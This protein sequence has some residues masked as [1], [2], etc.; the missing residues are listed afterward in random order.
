MKPQDEFAVIVAGVVT[1][2]TFQL[3]NSAGVVVAELGT[4]SIAGVGAA[5]LTMNHTDALTT[6]SALAWTT[7][8]P[9][10]PGIESVAL[11]GPTR[12]AAGVGGARTGGS[13]A[14][15]LGA[16]DQSLELSP[17]SAYG[18]LVGETAAGFLQLAGTTSSP[19]GATAYLSAR[20]NA[21]T[22][23]SLT[24][25]SSRADLEHDADAS[26]SSGSNAHVSVQGNNVNLRPRQSFGRLQINGRNGLLPLGSQLVQLGANF[27]VGVAFGFFPGLQINLTMNVGDLAIIDLSVDMNAAAAA[28]VVCGSQITVFQPNATFNNPTNVANL[29]S[30]PVT[31]LRSSIAQHYQFTAI[32]SGVHQFQAGAAA[33]LAGV[34]TAIQTHTTLR[35]QHFAID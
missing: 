17:G 18:G 27:G 1:A 16:A 25:N 2:S 33:P 30:S 6:N 3:L 19:D 8:P 29:A 24:I 35:V 28:A 12:V 14:M 10:T 11:Q 9:A 34:F 5:A 23:R 32:M 7:S 26:I 4:S 15:Y 13:V 20:G 22:N 31:G 21:F